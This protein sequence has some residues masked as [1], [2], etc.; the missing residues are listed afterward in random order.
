M[1]SSEFEFH[2]KLKTQLSNSQKSGNRYFLDWLYSEAEKEF[3]TI[4]GILEIGSG[5]GISKLFFKRI[6]VT[7]TDLLEFEENGV[8]GSIDCS[9]LPYKTENFVSAFGMDVIH[10]LSQPIIALSEL[11][12]VI[13]W[14][15]NS[16]IV[17][18]EP[19]VSL[20]SFLPYKLFHD[21]KTTFFT[22]G[23]RKSQFVNDSPEDGDQSIPRWLFESSKGRSLI[24]TIFPLSEFEIQTK[25]ICWLSF[26][27]TGGLTRPSRIPKSVIA[28]A[29]NIEN[30]IPKIIMK[31]LASRMIV[32]IRLKRV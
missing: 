30:K 7:R 12:R 31:H 3:Q 19:Y 27:L 15:D 18:V 11:K 5:G 28:V 2:Q 9:D 20:F 22:S 26:F 25:H 10:H 24:S 23:F 17:L 13:K 6:D 21:E 29:I 14:G 16:V 8:I 32:T 4:T 1:N